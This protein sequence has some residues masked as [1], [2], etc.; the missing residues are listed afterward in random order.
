MRGVNRR[1]N[2]GPAP[3]ESDS[4][5]IL[6]PGRF[7][8]AVR[9]TRFPPTAALA[10]LVDRF[11]VVEWDLPSGEQHRQQV[12]SHPCANLSL[13]WQEGTWLA[14]VTT[15][16]VVRELSG[17]GWNVAAMTT[18]GGLGAFLSGPAAALTDSYVSMAD[19]V[20]VPGDLLRRCSDETGQ[21]RSGPERIGVLATA[22]EHAVVRDRVEA[23]REVAQ[24][25][26]LA[27]RDRNL[28]T[29]K[30]LAALAGYGIRTL[31]RLFADYVGVPPAWVLRRYRLIDA[32]E[33]VRDGATVNWADVA[34]ELGYADQA[35]LIRDFR[36]ALGV[37]PAAYARAQEAQPRISAR[38]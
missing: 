12:L 21:V 18:P 7:T 10:G 28:R 15:R 17:S 20:A 36:S 22:L 3:V 29:A 13:G 31:Q 30:D 14:G 34:R 35:H 6:H 33:A 2:S 23:A 11:W 16:V 27:E 32:A 5:G 37:T 24:I 38:S 25:A 1:V 26:G 4:R 9:L 8:Q 19:H